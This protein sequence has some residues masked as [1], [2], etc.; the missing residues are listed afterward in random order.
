[1]RIAMTS[2]V[3]DKPPASIGINLS[4]IRLL[5]SQSHTPQTASLGNSVILDGATYYKLNAH[6]IKYKLTEHLVKQSNGSLVDRGANGGLAGAD[7]RI[8]E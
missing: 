7:V 3:A 8:L 6:N 4:N 2:P 5:M 1:M